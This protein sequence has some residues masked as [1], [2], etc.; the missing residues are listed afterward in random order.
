M[1]AT[2]FSHEAFRLMEPSH[3]ESRLMELS[4]LGSLAEGTIDL[5]AMFDEDVS[6]TGSFDLRRSRLNSFQKMLQAIPIPAL[7]VDE[8]CIVTF[9]NRACERATGQS[10]TIGGRRFS[11]LFPNR[12]DGARAEELIEKAFHNRIPL[13]AEGI[14]G[15]DRIP[16]LGRIHFR[17]VR[18]QKMRMVLVI[19]EDITPS[20]PLSRTTSGPVV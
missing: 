4:T 10:E 1:N 18:I 11:V 20:E 15:T 19:I 7:L 5:N 16:M 13:V 8:S 6:S 9:I 2:V 17:S 3:E 14:L 12:A